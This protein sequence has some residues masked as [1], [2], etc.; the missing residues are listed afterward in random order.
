MEYTL[1]FVVFLLV[2]LAVF[3][4]AIVKQHEVSIG[5]VKIGKFSINNIRLKPREDK[6][7]N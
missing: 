2:V 5:S 7:K 6:P 3:A 1:Y 4:I